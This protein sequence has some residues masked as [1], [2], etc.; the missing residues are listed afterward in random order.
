MELLYTVTEA[1]K[2][3]R[4][5]QNK[6]YD[7]IHAGH[8]KGLKL[9]SMKIPRYEIIRFLKDNIDMDLTDI[10]NVKPIEHNWRSLIHGFS[11]QLN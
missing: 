7:L 8:I 5:N 6:V 10:E 2:L 3:L 4:V 9:G 1:S 11:L